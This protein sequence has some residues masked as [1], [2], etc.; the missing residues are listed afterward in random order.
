[1]L[2]LLVHFVVA[3]I[4]IPIAVM[5]FIRGYKKRKIMPKPTTIPREVMTP[6]PINLIRISHRRKHIKKKL[7][8]PIKEQKEMKKRYRK[9][10]FERFRK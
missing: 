9:Q 3:I 5:I 4:F 8:N 6:F 2:A 7:V 10:I 1:M